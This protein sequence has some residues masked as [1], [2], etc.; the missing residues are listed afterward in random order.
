MQRSQKIE[1][2]ASRRRMMIANGLSIMQNGNLNPLERVKKQMK[3]VAFT[4]HNID[5]L[6]G[7]DEI[8]YCELRRAPQHG[9]F[10]HIVTILKQ[11][12]TITDPR[13]IATIGEQFLR[14]PRLSHRALI[15]RQRGCDDEIIEFSSNAT[16]SS[17]ATVRYMTIEDD[18]GTADSGPDST[19]CSRT[20]PS[21]ALLRRYL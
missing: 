16:V 3:S 6:A 12:S 13:I 19:S 18:T 4:L 9:S 17:K 5:L 11:G 14:N 8:K 7:A 20:S 1:T 21:L 15:I 2:K 10:P